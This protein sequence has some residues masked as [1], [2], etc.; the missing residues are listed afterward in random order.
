MDIIDNVF[1]GSLA[2]HPKNIFMLSCDAFGVLPPVSKLTNDQ[3]VFQFISGYTAKIPGTESDIKK[4]VATFSPCFGGPFMPR[5]IKDYA[6]LFKKKIKEYN[7]QCWLINTGWWGGPYGIGKRIDLSITRQI[8]NHC[9]NNS[10]DNNSFT[11]S[12]VLDLILPQYL[13][14]EKKINLD[15]LKKWEDKKK[16]HIAANKLNELFN[17][18][19]IDLN[20]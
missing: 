5:F 1:Q 17:K 9:I 6:N 16:Y 20:N 4:P 19:F 3:A 11:K 7:A 14:K 8:L 13:D 12:E 15:P 18:N 2:P 10:F